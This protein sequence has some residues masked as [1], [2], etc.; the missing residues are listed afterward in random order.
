MKEPMIIAGRRCDLYGFHLLRRV[1][2][3][4][5]VKVHHY[6]ILCASSKRDLQGASRL[7]ISKIQSKKRMD[8]EARYEP[9]YRIRIRAR[10]DWNIMRFKFHRTRWAEQ[11]YPEP[12]QKTPVEYAGRHWNGWKGRVRR[13]R[14]D[15][16]F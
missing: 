16:L 8:K 11:R 10:R 15:K 2:V 13:R 5:K 14:M 7:R 1:F 3:V 12:T 6:P 4:M 9:M